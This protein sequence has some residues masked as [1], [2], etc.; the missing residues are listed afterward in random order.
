MITVGI[1]IGSLATKC[2]ALD[3][4]TD[5]LDYHICLTSGDSKKAGECAYTELLKK[6][7][8]KE[9]DISY[10]VTT[11]YGRENIPFSNANITEISAHAIGISFFFPKVKTLLDIGGQD[12]KAIKIGEDGRVEDFVMND[13]CAAGT[14]RF[15]EVIAKALGVRLEDMGTISEQTDTKIKIS[16]MCAVFAE[17]E[18]ISLVSKGMPVPEIIK[19]VHYSIAEK[20]SVLLKKICLTEPIAMSGGVAKNIGVV[21]ELNKIFNFKLLV[22]ET[23]QIIGAVG[24]AL[25]AQKKA[26]R[27]TKNGK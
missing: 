4:N 19:G 8:I 1:D 9:N 27:L 25:I 5:K 23:P 21:N 26:E 17:S 22:P 2:V 7:G 24:A 13:K 20:S 15:L 18:V 11:G 10:V 14:G 16:N 12:S 6:S 3:T